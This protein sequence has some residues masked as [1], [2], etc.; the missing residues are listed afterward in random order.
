MIGDKRQEKRDKR[1]ETRDRRQETRDRRQEARDKRQETRDKRQGKDFIRLFTHSS[2]FVCYFLVSCLLFS[3]KSQNELFTDN[4]DALRF[5]EEAIVFDTIL[6]GVPTATKRLKVY[7]PNKK[8]VRIK[9]VYIGSQS[10]QEYTVLLNGEKNIEFSDIELLGGDSLLVIVFANIENRDQNEIY[11]AYDSLMFELPNRLQNVKL[12]TW[13]ENV[14]VV[15]GNVPCNTVWD[16]QRPYLLRG[17]V[18]IPSGCELTIQKGVRI[19]AF[20]NAKIEVRGSLLVNGKADTVVQ[21]K[22]FR[23]E[24]G[25]RN[26]LGA[27]EGIRFRKTSTNNAIRFATIENARVGVLVDTSEVFVEG[28]KIQNMSEVGLVGLKSKVFLRNTLINNCL[29][30]LLQATNGGEYE[31]AHCTLAN[32]EFF[33]NRQDE[34]GS[35]FINQN[36]A[37]SMA[38]RLFNNIFWGNL[39]DEVVFSGANLDLSAANNIFRTQLYK[40]VLNT[41]QNL[42]NLTN[43]RADSLFKNPRLFRYE[44]PSIS[45]AIGKGVATSITTDILGKPRK[46]P[47]DIGAYEF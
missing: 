2:I 45:P 20:N 29:L 26:V 31:I 35:V 47:P 42:I 13:A 27:W 30:R 11:Q 34:A 3:C 32:Y 43:Q 37:G 28:T 6:A 9:R 24:F 17:E 12:L 40:E 16:N 21:F 8:A 38:I 41:N 25:L 23:Q 5:S 36:G 1:Q 44:L 19:Y 18:T 10:N 7:N 39:Q 14:R 22:Y 4:P 46:N 33:F 15:S